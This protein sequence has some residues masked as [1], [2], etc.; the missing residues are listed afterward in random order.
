M[1][2]LRPAARAAIPILALVLAKYAQ[3]YTLLKRKWGLSRP[4]IAL[5]PLNQAG[6]APSGGEHA[7]PAPRAA[8]P[9]AA[10][11]RMSF[12]SLG[13]VDEGVDE[14][15][16]SLFGRPSGDAPSVGGG[17]FLDDGQG[18]EDEPQE[19]DNVD[20]HAK[21]KI[22]WSTPMHI[23][24][25]HVARSQ[26]V[27]NQSR[28]ATRLE[29]DARAHKIGAWYDKVVNG[30]RV[31]GV[32]TEAF[33]DIDDETIVFTA[34]KLV[35]AEG[36][37]QF[38][39]NSNWVERNQSTSFAI[40]AAIDP[41]EASEDMRN[42]PGDKL[43]DRLKMIQGLY[44]SAEARWKQYAAPSAHARAHHLFLLAHAHAVNLHSIGHRACAPARARPPA[45]A[46]VW[47]T[48]LL[49]LPRLCLGQK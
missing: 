9:L 44:G 38:W 24:L 42:I 39:G 12:G 22:N 36:D 19:P 3:R 31:R 1:G 34:P 4:P 25:L 46:Q 7:A 32:G 40:P 49:Q 2:A 43:A 37:Y 27:V 45:A 26:D 21:K 15:A 14:G 13:F 11:R 41:N 17:A 16:S 29:I 5:L 18:D 10:A 30:E 28:K 8:A 23:R 33:Q 47:P 6:T 35:P 48:H 20:P